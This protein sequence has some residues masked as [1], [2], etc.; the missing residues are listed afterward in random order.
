MLMAAADVKC[1]DSLCTYINIYVYIYIYIPFHSPFQSLGLKSVSNLAVEKSLRL[2]R[3]SQECLEVEGLR[4]EA[5]AVFPHAP[6][7]VPAGVQSL[8]PLGQ[9]HVL[10]VCLTLSHLL[11][12]GTHLLIVLLIVVH[13]VLDVLVLGQQTLGLGQRCGNVFRGHSRL[14]AGQP[15]LEVVQVSEEALQLAGFAQRLLAPLHSVVQLLPHFLDLCQVTL[16][17]TRLIWMF[18][19]Q[20]LCFFRQVV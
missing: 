20:L 14:R 3:I 15:G 1:S 13:L 10:G 17:L 4:Q 6:Q 12:H 19:G 9:E 8:Q 7:L 18:L 5:V 2:L 16:D 11:A